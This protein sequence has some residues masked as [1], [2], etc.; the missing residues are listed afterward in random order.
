MKTEE[1][2]NNNNLFLVSLGAELLELVVVCGATEFLS[3][4]FLFSFVVVTLLFF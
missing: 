4:L 2:K 3:H 1:E